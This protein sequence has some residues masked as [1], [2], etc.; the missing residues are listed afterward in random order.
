MCFVFV[1]FYC[2]ICSHAVQVIKMLHMDED[3]AGR[4]A[5]GHH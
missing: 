3:A 4:V 5:K 1:W 2:L